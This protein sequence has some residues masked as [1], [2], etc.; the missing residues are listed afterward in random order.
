MDLLDFGRKWSNDRIFPME[1]R[2]MQHQLRFLGHIA[3]HP[4][5]LTYVILL[6]MGKF[7]GTP[8]RGARPRSLSDN[9]L[10]ALVAFQIPETQWWS[11]TQDRQLWRKA[12]YDGAEL[13]YSAWRSKRI[14]AHLARQAERAEVAQVEQVDPLTL[15]GCLPGKAAPEEEIDE[16]PFFPVFATLQEGV[17]VDD[18]D[19]YPQSEDDE[20]LVEEE[21]HS[22]AA[23]EDAT[24]AFSL[25]EE[26]Q[27]KE[28]GADAENPPPC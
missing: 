18:Q 7:R 24:S 19:L 2:V 21:E 11:L 12:L 5:Q 26:L 28:D 8:I 16:A 3:R 17:E 25:L 27:L 1:I 13:A 10:N 9:W 20:D 14:Q 6:G 22:T 4:N 23:A 15:V